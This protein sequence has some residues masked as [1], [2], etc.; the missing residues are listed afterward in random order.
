MRAVIYDRTC[1]WV[2]RGLSPAWA[3]GSQL[4]RAVG[5][6]DEV[7]GVGSWE[8]ALHWLAARSR[9]IDEIQYWGHGHWGCALVERDVLDARALVSGHPLHAPLTALRDRLAPDALVWFRTC[10]TFGARRGIEL[11]E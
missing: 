3:V 8:E 9:P 11:A 7:R 2:R 1:V 10:E 4:Y 5:R 6:I